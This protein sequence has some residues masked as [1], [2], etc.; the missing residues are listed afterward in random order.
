M[1]RVDALCSTCF[2][3]WT[4]KGD[5]MGIDTKLFVLILNFDLIF[6]H[7]HITI[8]IVFIFL[9]AYYYSSDSLG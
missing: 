2:L 8:I 4:L 7:L 1:G 3:I 9:L 5:N 6:P